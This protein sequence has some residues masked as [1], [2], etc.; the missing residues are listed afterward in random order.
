MYKKPSQDG[1]NAYD[2]NYAQFLNRRDSLSAS[3]AGFGSKKS[4][5][6]SCQRETSSSAGTL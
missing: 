1:A 3:I 4:V 2:V 6:N 5:V